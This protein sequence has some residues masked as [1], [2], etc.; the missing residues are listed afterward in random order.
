MQTSGSTNQFPDYYTYDRL[1]HVLFILASRA[2][3]WH[4][5][6][7]LRDALQEQ[8]DPEEA[9]ASQDVCQHLFV[10]HSKT[11]RV[12]VPTQEEELLDC[13]VEEVKD[14]VNDRGT[15]LLIKPPHLVNRA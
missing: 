3:L 8:D 15:A 11:G 9:L 2:Q 13:C 1:P 7:D 4:I 10:R 5:L 12:K 14:F 6:C